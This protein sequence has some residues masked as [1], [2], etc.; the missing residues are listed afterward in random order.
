MD[1]T[2]CKKIDGS[3]RPAAG[4]ADPAGD[5]ET[6]RKLALSHTDREMRRATLNLME[7]VENAREMAEQ[8]N[9]KRRRADAALVENEAKLAEERGSAEE[10]I[11]ISEE[12]YR[13]LFESIDEGFCLIEMIYDE[14]G[15]PWD[16]RFIEC[17]PAFEKHTGLHDSVGRTI[18][19]LF[20]DHESHWFETYGRIALT[21]QPERFEQIARAMGRVFDVYAFPVGEADQGRVAILF[22]D[23]TERQER[24]AHLAFLVDLSKGLSDL[25]T[26][27][28]A[29]EMFGERI[30]ELLG[31]SVCAFISIDDT[32]KIARIS[33][34][35]RA[36]GTASLI[37]EY[38][39]RSYVSDEFGRLLEAGEPVVV[40]DAATDPRMENKEGISA[41]GIGAFVNVPL[42]RDDK[43]VFAIGIYRSLP[44]DWTERQVSLLTEI[45][46]RIWT[47]IERVRAQEATAADLRDTRVLQELGA[48]L[49]P[50]TAIQT[51]YEEIN[52]AAIKLSDADAG[53]VQIFDPRTKEL[54]LLAASGFPAD[55]VKRFHR[56]DAASAT[57]CGSALAKGGRTFVD[58][59]DPT[60]DDPK[61]DLRWHLDAGYLSAQSTVL[62]GRSG[63]TIGM[64]T[65]HWRDHRRPTERQQ[66]YLDL[67]A[68]QAADLIEQ[69]Q[70]EKMIGESEER[71]RTL[72]DSMNE[73]FVIKEAILGEN[74]N[75]VDYRFIECNPAFS[76]QTG[77]K[78]PRGHTVRGL[79]PQV[80]Q[81]WMDHYEKVIRTGEPA[82]FE[83]YI[84]PLDRWLAVSASRLGGAG[85]LR[86]AVVFMDISGRK[87]S[88]EALRRIHEELE[89]RVTDRTKDLR[90]ALQRLRAETAER[91]KLEDAR[92]D[93]LKRLVT[94]Q[95]EERKRISRDLHDELGQY[96]TAVM[97][98]LQTLQSEV[99]QGIKPGR[100]FDDLKAIV[101]ELMKA[102]H[103]QAWELRPTELDHFGLE[104]ALRHYAG[105]WSGRTG[106]AVDFQAVGWGDRRILPDFEIALYRV[107]QE[108]LTN[109]ARHAEATKVTVALRRNGGTRVVITD[110]GK[111]FDRE[112]VSQR[113][114]LL[115]MKERLLL[116]GGTLDI[117]SA[118]GQGTVVTAHIDDPGGK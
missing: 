60:L 26:T 112:A 100:S 102:A 54:I 25:S 82:Q 1:D 50:H 88:E 80:E 101:G 96:L 45:S 72:F 49:L 28:E 66:R 74:K 106:I 34:E 51:L 105:D 30:G 36:E 77:L 81:A 16:Y 39:L 24:E 47:R 57:S 89:I 116:V 75:V 22:N 83:A 65:T 95:E 97:L 9:A 107:V 86:V 17:N 32:L 114:G 31:A 58:F 5:L 35:W 52:Q 78:D 104:A 23:V 40:S 68:R 12:K 6:L 98:N 73:A 61:G 41:L 63:K 91:R 37:G 44:K 111:G 13:T 33:D 93:L 69:R 90:Q 118:P 21:G 48:R 115:G 99:D 56:I 64:L 79:M 8:E 70:A 53:K 92:H 18:R 2:A 87:R 109:V 110:D 55:S 42:I 38:A 71:L 117:E 43:W 103:R 11:R 67:L 19:E 76:R 85:S 113:L 29:M 62:V 27:R 108:A 7:D 46:S 84:A 59:D 10:A 4:Q 94:T 20:P 15:A 14:G 3:E